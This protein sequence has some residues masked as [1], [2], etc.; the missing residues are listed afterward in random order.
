M[1]AVIAGASGLVGSR[2]LL[3][4]LERADI[5]TVVS[6]SRRPL[7]V[8]SPKLREVIV[9]DFATLADHAAE[10]RGDVYY[11]CLGTT[12]RAAGSQA[13][14]R[15]VDY[16]AVVAFGRVALANGAR[17]LTVISAAGAK[18][19]SFVFYNRV[20]G[21]AENALATLG[22]NA[23]VIFQPGLLMGERMESRPGERGA[24]RAVETLERFLP[25]A[26]TRR[27]ATP[28]DR[29]ASRMIEESLRAGNGV[30]RIAAKDI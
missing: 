6:V 17:S 20:K 12:I 2:L 11:C 3:Q 29:L 1:I 8:A 15:R 10:L 22:L 27:I 16:D 7:G 19:S 9:A 30:I 13:A 25:Q 23:L 26:W 5:A 24:I 18:A 28:V 21:D 4:L 14:F